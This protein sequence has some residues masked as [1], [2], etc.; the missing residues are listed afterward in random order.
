[1]HRACKHAYSARACSAK[2]STSAES[3][4]GN[5]TSTLRG[6]FLRGRLKSPHSAMHPLPSHAVLL[7][8]LVATHPVHQ[9]RT[10]DLDVSSASRP[11]R[12]C[13][14]SNSSRVMAAGLVVILAVSKSSYPIRRPDS[15]HA[16]PRVPRPAARPLASDRSSVTGFG[17]QALHVSQQWPMGLELHSCSGIK[18]CATAGPS[19]HP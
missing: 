5:Q 8:Y 4:G 19:R 17:P 6:Q 3:L 10:P 18:P 12:G 16:G 15:D 2:A 9:H 14:T 1:M 11:S 7:G 13:S